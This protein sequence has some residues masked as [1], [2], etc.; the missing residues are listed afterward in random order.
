MEENANKL[1]FKCIDFNS[2]TGETVYAECIYVFLSKFCPRR[3]M[4]CWSLTNTAVT[5]EFPVPQI[6]RKS[7]QVKEQWNGKFYLQS[8]WG[9]T[10]YIK[11]WKYKNLWINN[12]LLN[13]SAE[14]LNSNFPR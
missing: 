3:W 7:K 11:H 5:S 10:R 9:K 2:S 1:H 14:N 4:P 12:N 6:D 13:I 8:V